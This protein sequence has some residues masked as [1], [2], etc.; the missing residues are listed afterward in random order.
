MSVRQDLVEEP[1]DAM[2]HEHSVQFYEDESFLAG[3]VADFLAS[4][5]KVGEP[6][7]VIATLEHRRAF[8]RRLDG[9]GIDARAVRRSGQ[10]K[11]LDAQQTLDHFMRGGSP[12]AERF[13]GV[14]GRVILDAQRGRE[15]RPVRAYGEMVDVLW[16]SGNVEGAIRLEELWNELARRHRFSL[17]CAYAMA[18]FYRAGDAEAFHRVC[19]AHGHVAPAE[20]YTALDD[21]ARLLEISRLQ[22]RA[23]AFEAEVVQREAVEQRL[24]E[25]VLAL[26]ARER[27]IRERESEL[28]DA[29]ESAAE[30]IHF[31][32][33]DGTIEWANAA[34][35][36]MLGYTANE[37]IGRN[38]AEFHV[39]APVIENML[40]RLTRGEVLRD[41]EARVRHKDGSI[42]YVMVNSN[43]RWK[44]GRFVHTRCFS[45][46]VTELRRAAAAREAALAAERA[47]RETADRARAEAEAARLAAEQAN[48][49]KSDFLAVM[50]HE[51]RTPL[52]AIG[53]Y[54]DLLELGIHGPVTPQQREVLARV[55]R[56]QRALLGLVN[57]VLNYARIETG[58]IAYHLEHVPVEGAIRAAEAVVAPQLRAKNLRFAATYGAE[59]NTVRA[60]PDK[61]QQILLNLLSNAA[62][63][64]DPGG[65]VRVD[66][67]TGNAAIHI[68]VSDTGIGVPADKLE[69][70]FDP[71]VQ[72]DTN[73]TRTH[74][75]VGLGLAISRDLAR[76]MGG[77]LAAT[78]IEGQGSRFTISLPSPR[79]RGHNSHQ[80]VIEA[81]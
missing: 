24:R 18:N 3:V 70:I 2:P 47:A 4:G 5:L 32:A 54:V 6:V 9:Y 26:D 27:E 75:G 8:V 60:D 46:D 16:K 39:D 15:G 12:N 68:H 23:R 19:A 77:D 53:G 22:Q 62:K 43:A 36:E 79:A 63:F 67:E 50:S 40:A 74:D 34:E 52:N 59:A 29:L 58:S 17:L 45:R 31:V 80:A 66:V 28:R 51:L 10:L 81:R 7:I 30:G 42:R 65:L 38:I 76:G 25:T 41:A 49:A 72:V 35:L 1:V 71:F 73:Y 61:L 44:D 14:I 78:S 55:Q 33:A 69:M 64:T 56:S 20:S 48:R 37:Y 57:Q 21:D 11:L 13:R